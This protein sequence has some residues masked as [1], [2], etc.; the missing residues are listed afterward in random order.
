M[1]KLSK[2]GDIEKFLYT[3]QFI[4]ISENG[5]T[6]LSV[7]SS[8]LCQLK[9]DMVICFYI[10]YNMYFEQIVSLKFFTG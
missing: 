9:S 8:N 1:Y 4:F 10:F 7:Y 5:G 3:D 2:G 6:K